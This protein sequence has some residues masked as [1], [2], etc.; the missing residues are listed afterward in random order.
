[1]TGPRTKSETHVS[2][3]V[4]RN[5]FCLREHR[6]LTRKLLVEKTG[7]SQLLFIE[8][9]TSNGHGSLPS[10]SVDQLVALA[11][12]LK[13]TPQWLLTEYK[14]PVHFLR[15]DMGVFDF[16]TLCPNTKNFY[17]S[18]VGKQVRQWRENRQWTLTELVDKMRARGARIDKSGLAQFEKHYKNRGVS[19]DHFMIYVEMMETTP[20]KLLLG[21]T[22]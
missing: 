7:C 17:A 20:H 4:G 11:K 15:R 21:Q 16:E 6:G 5:T 18:V 1:M 14:N 12:E 9:G 3:I 2:R 19:V 13:T 8:N 22:N 10:V